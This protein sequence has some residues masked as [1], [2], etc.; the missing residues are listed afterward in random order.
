MKAPPNSY[1]ADIGGSREKLIYNIA[2]EQQS[3][4]NVLVQ[5]LVNNVGDPLKVQGY[6]VE[7]LHSS[8]VALPT[9]QGVSM[10][11]TMADLQAE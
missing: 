1:W 8:L 4:I 11:Q 5:I 6:K 7:S 10:A 3:L 9:L 2:A